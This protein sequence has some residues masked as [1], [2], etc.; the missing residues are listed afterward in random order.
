MND[1]KKNRK[2]I[3]IKR[4]FQ[5]R[6][7][8][9]VIGLLIICCLCSAAVLYPLLSSELNS[10]LVSAH[11]DA[12]S[13][14]SQ[15]MLA[16]LI[17]NL[18][19]IIVASL[20]SVVVFLYITHKIAGPLYRFERICEEIGHGKFNVSTTPREKDQ[21]KGLSAAFG[22]MLTKLRDRCSDQYT[23]IEEARNKLKQIQGSLKDTSLSSEHFE[24]VDKLLASLSGEMKDSC[25]QDKSK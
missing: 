24:P 12:S 16:I 21:L 4:G 17:G 9:W 15:L 10:K 23:R 1:T 2:T 5:L 22:E 8:I 6:F 20:A 18:L 11:R 13:I 19:A 3:F 7:I 14:K 25:P